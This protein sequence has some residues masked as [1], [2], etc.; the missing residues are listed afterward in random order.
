[1]PPELVETIRAS[2]TAVDRS[3][4][5]RVKKSRFAEVVEWLRSVAPEDPQSWASGIDGGGTVQFHIIAEVPTGLSA[6][7]RREILASTCS[8]LAASGFTYEGVLHRP[9]KDNH[10]DNWHIH[11]LVHDRTCTRI[12]IDGKEV[13]DHAYRRPVEG[14]P[15]RTN[16]PFRRD[17]VWKDLGVKQTPE[18]MRNWLTA[19]RRDYAEDVN[20]ILAA[21]GSSFSF[22]HRKQQREAWDQPTAHVGRNAWRL[23]ALGVPTVIGSKNAEIQWRRIRYKALKEARQAGDPEVQAVTDSRDAADGPERS[24][25]DTLLKTTNEKKRELVTFQEELA[26]IQWQEE[27][28]LS[29]SRQTEEYCRRKAEELAS[30]K[31]RA[32][33]RNREQYEERAKAAAAVAHAVERE[34]RPLRQAIADMRGTAE[35]KAGQLRE[36]VK[37]EIMAIFSPPEPVVSQEVHLSNKPPQI[38]PERANSTPS[39][40]RAVDD[41]RKEPVPTE[42]LEQ[43]LS[44]GPA[45]GNQSEI[46][47]E[48]GTPSNMSPTSPTSKSSASRP[49]RQKSREAALKMAAVEA[50]ASAGPVPEDSNA[51]ASSL[52]ANDMPAAAVDS[53]QAGKPVHSDQDRMKT[54]DRDAR[55]ESVLQPGRRTEKRRDLITISAKLTKPIGNPFK[56]HSDAFE[57]PPI[58]VAKLKIRQDLR[59]LG[60]V[61]KSIIH[62]SKGR[63]P[64]SCCTAEGRV[65]LDV[66]VYGNDAALALEAEGEAAVRDALAYTAHKMRHLARERRASD[67]WQALFEKVVERP[68]VLKIESGKT[69][70]DRAAFDDGA[71]DLLNTIRNTPDADRFTSEILDT[72]ARQKKSRELKDIAESLQQAN[73]GQP[74]RPSYTRVTYKLLRKIIARAMKVMV[75]KGYPQLSDSASECIRGLDR[76]MLHDYKRRFYVRPKQSLLSDRADELVINSATT[77]IKEKALIVM[78]EPLGR[79]WISALANFE[80]DDDLQPYHIKTRYSLSLVDPLDRPAIIGP[81]SAPKPSHKHYNVME[82][83][84]EDDG[85]RRDRGRSSSG[86]SGARGRGNSPSK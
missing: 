24:S 45:R 17:K 61:G 14:R 32:S 57:R 59:W 83:L 11:L 36:F 67:Q 5:I 6:G 63:D 84:R 78:R 46:A 73:G 50:P 29:R 55:N 7:E 74:V 28:A 65:L 39:S 4:P 76:D 13:W 85:P 75:D 48:S 72:I 18:G 34:L 43:A 21:R 12:I 20:T 3:E 44:P 69:V 66:R 54:S 9:S 71:W 58:R 51:R 49:T 37:R 16:R 40:G 80:K 8:R 33:Q 86:F 2:G 35:I 41:R 42:R 10:P 79:C 68:H 53:A 60:Q 38:G 26:D 30:K 62:A 31:T 82:K 22:D 70:W 15:G 27:R 81:V 52:I 47:S 25:L 56:K 1:M 64:M 23:E 77:L 19:L